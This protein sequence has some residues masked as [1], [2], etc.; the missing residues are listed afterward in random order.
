MPVSPST[1]GRRLETGIVLYVSATLN[2]MGISYRNLWIC[3]PYSS[4]RLLPPKCIYPGTTSPNLIQR[5]SRHAHIKS[6]HQIHP[7]GGSSALYPHTS[8]KLAPTLKVGPTPS[9]F[10]G[11]F[12]LAWY[13]VWTH[14][15]KQ[16]LQ[17]CAGR[18]PDRLR[19]RK[20]NPSRGGS[21]ALFQS[22]PQ[23]SLDCIIHQVKSSHIGKKTK[24]A[25]FLYFSKQIGMRIFKL[26]C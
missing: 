13:S 11:Q 24:N 5:T 1:T 3:V 14:T 2:H 16:D 10:V 26:M 17:V 22:P 9:H 23:D 21:L 25:H 7:S 19:L 18:Y 20:A 6:Y 4:S 12:I 15:C 8:I